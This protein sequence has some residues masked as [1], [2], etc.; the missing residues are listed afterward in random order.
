M[1]AQMSVPVVLA[2]SLALFLE[3]CYGI[4]FADYR[5]SVLSINPGALQ[6][7]CKKVFKN[8]S[9]K[10]VSLITVMDVLKQR[11]DEYTAIPCVKEFLSRS[12]PD[13]SEECAMSGYYGKSI[14]CMMSPEAMAIIGKKNEDSLAPAFKCLIDNALP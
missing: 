7:Q 10:M 2:C 3:G 6:P 11:W 12:F 1:K 5:K 4:T 14:K 13:F 8:C 9:I